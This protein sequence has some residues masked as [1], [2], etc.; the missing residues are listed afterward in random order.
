M[1][2]C[3]FSIVDRNCRYNDRSYWVPCSRRPPH[4]DLEGFMRSGDQIATMSQATRIVVG[5]IGITGVLTV[6]LIIQF[7]LV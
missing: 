4:I 1:N 5:T 6:A 7:L 3:R 2:Y